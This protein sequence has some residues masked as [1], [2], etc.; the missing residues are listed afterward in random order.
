MQFR[1]ISKENHEQC[2]DSQTAAA[3]GTI[4]DTGK[5]CSI[6]SL[7]RFTELSKNISINY[8]LFTDL[9]L[10]VMLVRSRNE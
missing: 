9:P 6:K 1:C 3:D 8:K 5:V 4:C 7:I 2:L 10:R